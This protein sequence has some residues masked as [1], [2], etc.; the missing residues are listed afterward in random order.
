MRRAPN[1]NAHKR[2][3]EVRDSTKGVGPAC[4]HRGNRRFDL[5]HHQVGRVGTQRSWLWVPQGAVPSASRIPT[6]SRRACLLTTG[7]AAEKGAQIG[8]SRARDEL[9]AGG[10][11]LRDAAGSIGSEAAGTYAQGEIEP[12]PIVL[13]CDGGRELDECRLAEPGHEIVA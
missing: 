10:E 5:V 12:G 6:R 9:L 3:L 2:S 8:A 4:R 1:A 11:G 7:V 13:V